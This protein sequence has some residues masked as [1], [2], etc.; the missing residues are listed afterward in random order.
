MF[1]DY[2]TITTWWIYCLLTFNKIEKNDNIFWLLHHF[3][4]TNWPLLIL[5]CFSPF[6]PLALSPWPQR[7]SLLQP[8]AWRQA[9]GQRWKRKK[10]LPRNWGRSNGENKIQ[11]TH[12]QNTANEVTCQGGWQWTSA[13]QLTWRAT[14]IL[15]EKGKL[16]N[17]WFLD[18]FLLFFFLLFFFI[19][20]SSIFLF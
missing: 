9:D 12:T 6:S 13:K 19:K 15:K 5:C 18:I 1:P 7:G 3:Q 17:A 11:D 2:F 14:G 20:G 8:Q 10:Q 16:E 4:M